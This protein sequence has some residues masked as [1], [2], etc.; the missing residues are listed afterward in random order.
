MAKD[1][2]IDEYSVALQVGKDE[3]YFHSITSIS[4]MPA[5]LIRIAYEVP[6]E[7]SKQYRCSALRGLI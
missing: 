4:S 6:G 5:V 3:A 7:R 2:Q 1:V